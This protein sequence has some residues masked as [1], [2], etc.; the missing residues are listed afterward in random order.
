[1]YKGELQDKYINYSGLLEKLQLYSL[2]YRRERGDTI[3]LSNILKESEDIT[4]ENMFRYSMNRTR[5]HSLP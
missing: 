5:R 3:Q 1:M 4:G 2:N